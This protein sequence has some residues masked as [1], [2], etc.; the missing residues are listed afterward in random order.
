MR[1]LVA[2][3]NLGKLAEL[4][5][6][7][8]GLPVELLSLRDV[9]ID[10]HVDEDADTFEGNARKKASEFARRSGLATLADDSGLEVDALGGA[11]GVRSARYA[12]EGA[13]DA[14]NLAKLVEA[15]GPHAER[16]ARFRCVLA[17]AAPSGEV[18]RVTEGRCEGRIIDV[19]RGDMGF[20]YDPVFVPLGGT[21]TLAELSA[22]EKNALSHRGEASRA[23]AAALA[24]LLQAQSQ[25]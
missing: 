19:P 1:L 16:S 20:G 15:I 6:L 2:T 22:E 12:G 8:A 7:F 14:R 11:P 25:Q 21:R 17:F 24:G 4:R 13:D 10:T 9:T 3:T 5:S 18:Q 23:M